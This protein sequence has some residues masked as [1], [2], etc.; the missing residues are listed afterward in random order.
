M[1]H[2][3]MKSS[4]RKSMSQA[5]AE[6]QMVSDISGI[7]IAALKRE[8]A[9]FK[10]KVARVTPGGP[11]GAEYEVTFSGAEKDLIAYAK[12]H[13]GFDDKP[14]NFMQLKKHLNMSYNDIEEI[15][16]KLKL[17]VLARNIKKLKN[18]FLKKTIPGTGAMFAQKEEVEIEEGKMKTIATMFDQGKSAE[19]IAKALKLPVG[20]VK[21][22]LGEEVQI[23]EK[24]ADSII[25]DLQKAYGDLK[26]KTI[27]P[28]MANKI[29]KHLDGQSFD[30]V[31]L[32][33]LT[34]AKIPFISTLARNKI[35]KKTGKFEELEEVMI[36]K[37]DGKKGFDYKGQ[38]ITD[39]SMDPSARFDVDPKK[40]YG[41]SDK[42]IKDLQ[43]AD[44]NVDN[45]K[46]GDSE[47][48][49]ELK[50]KLDKEKDQDALEK[51]LIAAQGQIN[52][53]KQKLENEKN[54]TLKPEPNPDTGEVPL[55]VGVA[56][57]HFKDKAKKEKED[58]Q[59]ADLT[60]SQIKKVHD[61]AD[62]LP[63]DSFRDR[64]GKK[65][66][67]AVRYAT[68]TK[69]IKKKLGIKEEVEIVYTDKK[70][71]KVV[72]KKFKN[73][74]EAR[75]FIRQ[76]D[77][78]AGQINFKPSS[79]LKREDRRLYVETIA[80]LK[81]KA[82]KSGMPYSIL[83]KVYDRGMAAWKGGHRPGASQ[84]QWAF[85]RV[86]SFVTKSSG[87]WGGADKDLAAKVRGSK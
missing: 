4:Y 82:E 48:E 54:K 34:K 39:P 18:K 71:R 83:K 37:V 40:Y 23:D 51:Q 59:E 49:K 41:L 58:V 38:F 80:G 65:Q 6:A 21:S 11:M 35:Y 9:K 61:K 62:D 78:A 45:V 1:E 12:E 30:V 46:K 19:E 5:I 7:S 86:N 25:K 56:Y 60:K 84:Q 55:T 74:S 13:L 73:D 81:K 53:L 70:T 75:K 69:M 15:S 64:Y 44:L 87:T 14:G 36:K 76:F 63:K 29:S 57:K 32:R 16:D 72:S 33:Q 10:I 8:A 79:L 52:I 50:I 66:G 47:K 20:T 17:K 28:E 68:A 2:T 85:A 27:S 77:G 3:I 24:I 67:D 22:I 26:G 31:T 43:E 42:Q